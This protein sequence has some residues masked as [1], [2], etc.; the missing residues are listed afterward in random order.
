MVDISFGRNPKPNSDVVICVGL[1]FFLFSLF[2]GKF[3]FLQQVA[4]SWGCCMTGDVLA[5]SATLVLEI[6]TSISSTFL[7]C[8]GNE[9]RQQ[10]NIGMLQQTPFPQTRFR[11]FAPCFTL[12]RTTFEPAWKPREGFNTRNI[13]P[14]KGSFKSIK[15]G[16]CALTMINAEDIHFAPYIT[17]ICNCKFIREWNYAKLLEVLQPRRWFEGNMSS[18]RRD[19]AEQTSMIGT[20]HCISGRKVQRGLDGWIQ[21]TLSPAFC[22]TS[23]VLGRLL[24]WPQV[25]V[26]LLFGINAE[27][28]ME[29][30]SLRASWLISASGVATR[31]S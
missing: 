2:D 3:L 22:C 9:V 16:W 25:L 11:G 18:F 4:R 24:R 20:K 5:Q 29:K 6:E 31:Y 19:E 26:G 30:H 13:G 23:D 14:R 27:T 28:A 21:A 12:Y 1:G 8:T 17:W 7:S 10:Q 15:S